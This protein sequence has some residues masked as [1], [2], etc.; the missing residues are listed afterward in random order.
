M[1]LRI[2][3]S[4]KRLL[5]GKQ[6]GCHML[7]HAFQYKHTGSSCSAPGVSD[8]QMRLSSSRAM[9]GHQHESP[10]R[11]VLLLP[12]LSN[13]LSV[14]LFLF[15]L[16]NLAHNSASGGKIKNRHRFAE[17]W[18]CWHLCWMQGTLHGINNPSSVT[19]RQSSRLPVPPASP[20]HPTAHPF[21]PRRAMTEPSMG[22]SQS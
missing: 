6:G 9:S 1:K 14:L 7:P 19:E 15:S 16:R 22:S 3:S 21:H 8:R 18:E 12:V 10:H 11:G 2:W 17:A 20:T 13:S 4:P 5:N